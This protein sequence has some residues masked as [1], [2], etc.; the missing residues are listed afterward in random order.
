MS[1]NSEDK[2]KYLEFIQSIITRMNTN[3]FLIKGWAT[4]ILSAIVALFA[5][6]KNTSF[7]YLAGIPI[8]IFWYLDTIYL[9]LERKYRALYNEAIKDNSTL[10][11]YD[12]KIDKAFIRN[13]RYCKFWTV[14]FSNT[15]CFFYLFLL[16]IGILGV[17][18]IKNSDQRNE[19]PT[20]VEISAID[21]LKVEQLQTANQSNTISIKKDTSIM[22]VDTN[23]KK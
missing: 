5:S 19:T 21:T 17:I 22:K 9:Q 13:D 18:F 23:F 14:L 20:K 11:L 12:L 1:T 8:L 2:R 16:A 10:L 15:I 6:T 7:L 4:T 3:S